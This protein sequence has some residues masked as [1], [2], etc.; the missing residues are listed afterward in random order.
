VET[1]YPEKVAKVVQALLTGPA[2]VTPSLRQAIAARTAIVD[3]AV[4][5]VEAV[6]DYLSV[7]LDKIALCAYRITDEDIQHLKNVGYDEDEIFEITLC[8]ALGTGLIR[9]ERGLAA[10]K[11]ASLCAYKF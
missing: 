3:E 6:P 4:P 10:L 1:I 2:H 9:V 11:G 8:A 7:Y 5:P